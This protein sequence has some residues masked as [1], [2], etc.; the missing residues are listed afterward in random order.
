MSRNEFLLLAREV[1]RD[2]DTNASSY[3][4]GRLG[5]VF[6]AKLL[7]AKL[8]Y[9]QGHDATIGDV[10][11]EIKTSTVGKNGFYQFCL[12]K[13]DRHGKTDCTKSDFVVLVGLSVFYGVQVWVVP[14][15]ALPKTCKISMSPKS[16]RFAAYRFQ[17]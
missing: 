3:R 16:K 4:V 9:H 10:R 7:G 17:W 5:E 8:V 2:L 1:F 12:N 14:C 13:N 15:A 6:A 11:Y